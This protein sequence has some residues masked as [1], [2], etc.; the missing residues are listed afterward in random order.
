[1]EDLDLA[2]FSKCSGS[3]FSNSIK[4][5]QKIRD[6]ASPVLK[7]EKIYRLFTRTIP[8]EI[9]IQKKDK[10]EEFYVDADSMKGIAVYL[11][12][13]AQ[14]PM[15]IVDLQIIE[16]FISKNLEMTN[17]AYYRIVLLS[18]I[19]YVE[20]LTQSDII[21]LVPYERDPNYI[22][23]ENLTLII[24]DPDKNETNREN[25]YVERTTVI[26]ENEKHYKSGYQNLTTISSE[27]A[28]Q[29][30]KTESSKDSDSMGNSQDKDFMMYLLAKIEKRPPRKLNLIA[31]HRGTI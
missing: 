15:V 12:V 16:E 25:F 1:M 10:D 17:R 24:S 6:Y 28:M 3:C 27:M 26:D 13:H 5:L 18:A 21:K 9:G 8:F 11:F 4:K 14:C 20:N 2:K 23:T 30:Q 29:D 7:Q 31:K 22:E 19:E